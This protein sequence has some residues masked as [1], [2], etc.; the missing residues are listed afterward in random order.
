MFRTSAISST[1]ILSAMLTVPTELSAQVPADKPPTDKSPAVA[2]A[3][4]ESAA[5]FLGD[6]TLAT[7]GP[8]GPGTF[9]LSVKA[10]AGKVTAE[11]SSEVQSRQQVTDI[12]TS[13]TSLV[14]KYVFDYQGNPVPVVVTLT[15]DKDK[16]GA[17]LD[18]ADGAYV[19][20]GSAT[21]K[22]K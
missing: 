4:P 5:A 7:Q 13:G 2:A 9:A 18:F 6:W 22:E 11:I 16:V 15:P 17:Q 3:T 10:D 12:S 21:K 8:N 14:L 20:T 1:L 19:M